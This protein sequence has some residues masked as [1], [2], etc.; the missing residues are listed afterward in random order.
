MNKT[1]K[2]RS[3]NPE[4]Y[5]GSQQNCKSQEELTHITDSQ[6]S[7]WPS[8][9]IGSHNSQLANNKNSRD[10][11]PDHKSSLYTQQEILFSNAL[12]KQEKAEIAR[13]QQW[14]L[15]I[16]NEGLLKNLSAKEEDLLK[17]K[18]EGLW[19]LPNQWLQM[20][21]NSSTSELNTLR[22]AESKPA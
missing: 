2:T 17:S 20:A 12:Q 1:T 16:Q 22:I 13:Q 8:A 9:G 15:S 7:K 4:N 10:P 21:K 18:Q 3:Y 6:P 5:M 19:V 14:K 11:P